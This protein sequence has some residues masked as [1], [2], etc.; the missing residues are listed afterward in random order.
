MR[1]IVVF[2][3]S[4]HPALVDQICA[5]LGVS[6]GQ[7]KLTKF[8]NKETNVEIGDSV[9]NKDV[10]I[11]QSGCGAVNDNL[12]ELLIMLAACKT[13]SAR[14]ITAVIPCFPYARQPDAP[15]KK[16]GMPLSRVPANVFFGY[17][18]ASTPFSLPVTPAGT[19]LQTP[20]LDRIDRKNPFDKM[21]D[22]TNE[23]NSDIESAATSPTLSPAANGVV[24]PAIAGLRLDSEPKV[25]HL[26]PRGIR[27]Q[28]LSQPSHL[29][30]P[31]SSGT[32]S[33]TQTCV[34][35]DQVN[36]Q[37][38]GYKHWV[39]RSGT[40]I[41]NLLV[42]AG[43]DHIITMDL[44]DPQFQGFFDIPVDNLYGQPLMVKYIR[45]R[46]P[47]WEDAVVVSPDAGGAK[48]ATVIADKLGM[49]FALIHKERRQIQAPHKSDMMLVGDVKGKVCILV[50]DIAD[51]SFTITKAAKVLQQNGA[52][53]IYA[54]ITH[55]IMSGDAVARIQSSCIDQVIVSNSI[56]QE[57]HLAGCNKMK[58]F[59][60]AP[61]F[62]EAIRRIHNGESV[63]M[64]FDVMD[65]I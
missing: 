42:T 15:Y 36:P 52:Q 64:L 54:I 56:P 58:V 7:V 51:T 16:N 49:E 13:A 35:S 32:G 5:R 4:S 46:I 6:P 39:A 1:N 28:A 10:F 18:G 43:A 14:R 2:S 26:A 61:I 19:P 40:L 27:P 48:R 12:M 44:H 23:S 29:A 53:K 65:L 41:A 31:S 57:E 3:G 22:S 24:I 30:I 63:S 20:S 55:A 33:P 25:R 9:R 47:N 11:I 62:A 38:A 60:V 21:F 45:E 8:A 59:N 50:D 37:K 17:T 34:T